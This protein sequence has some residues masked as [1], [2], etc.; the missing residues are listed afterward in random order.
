MMKN[1][2]F[3]FLIGMFLLCICSC[4]KADEQSLQQ[5]I[6]EV[7]A[8]D[9]IILNNLGETLSVLKGDGSVYNNVQLTGSSPNQILS[10]GTEIYVI[11]SRSNSIEVL[12]SGDLS[13][14]RELSVGNNK[15]PMYAA[16]IR[17]DV[18]AV[19]CFISQ[20]LEIV[21]IDTSSVL[22]SI[23]L[24][25]IDLPHDNPS[26]SGRPYPS[27]VAAGSGKVFV[28]LSN[29]TDHYGGLQAA[30]PGV[31]A[32]VDAGTY[33][34][35]DIIV[36]T[37]ADPVYARAYESY[38][39]VSCPGHYDGGF[40]GDGTIEMINAET[41]GHEAVFELAGCAPFTFHI[42]DER[43]LHASNAMSTGIPRIDLD[44]MEILENIPFASI[45]I[46]DVLVMDETIYALCFNEDALYM[47]DET[48]SVI[49]RVITGDG[50][51]AMLKTT[52]AAVPEEE[53]RVDMDIRPGISSPS[54]E[55]VFDA[56]V[57]SNLN[58]SY[59][60]VWEFGD[61]SS[62]EGRQV[63]HTYDAPGEYRVCATIMDDGRETADTSGFVRILESSPFATQVVEYSPAEGQFVNNDAFNDP[64]RA[65]GAPE[66]GG[67]YQADNTSQVSLGGIG[68]YIVLKFDHM[69]ENMPDSFDF[70]VFGNAFE[71]PSGA[72]KEP[73]IVEI[74][75][76]GEIWYLM[77][78][79][80]LAYPYSS[81]YQLRGGM[82]EWAWGYADISP[83]MAL[84]DGSDPVDFY[85]L[86]DD[87]L[88]PGIDEGSCGGDAFDIE[89]AVDPSSGESAGLE[90][91]RYIRI[92]TGL[93]SD[94]GSLGEVSTEV[95]A[96]A[97]IKPAG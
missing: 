25:E 42:S 21:D 8:D 61:G 38:I 93:D 70:I 59:S 40:V 3:T 74:S 33:E 44:A 68:G 29:L 77:P 54:Q 75:E 92:S 15:N 66:G 12:S 58:N 80:G 65:L 18:L 48:G 49:H 16:I 6:A 20:T 43:V 31:V 1:H 9:V 72:W 85:T 36:L 41:L 63:V 69:V 56:S 34:I 76:D 14:K 17:E 88:I 5:L 50:P 24:S 57:S 94:E 82:D 81:P 37:G 22:C 90:G 47:I 87:P 28:T 10:S 79:P 46:S 4:D 62:A 52:S 96:V 97:D 27:G 64:G 91:F 23:D 60:I 73:G 26:V 71:G 45:Y 13:I 11:N 53:I 2:I 7:S 30:G 19:S 83:V 86:F 89:W 78:G 55:I 95:D 32:V 51:I 39:I 84:P 67:I 35:V